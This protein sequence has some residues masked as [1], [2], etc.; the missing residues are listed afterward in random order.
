MQFDFWFFGCHI[1]LAAYVILVDA[2][3]E[4]KV[5]LGAES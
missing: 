2:Q 1:P 4:G 5:L 3:S